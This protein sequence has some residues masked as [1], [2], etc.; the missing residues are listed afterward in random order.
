VQKISPPPGFDFRTAVKY[1]IE[2]QCRT[3][4]EVLTVVEMDISVVSENME[5][6]YTACDSF[7]LCHRI[8]SGSGANMP[9]VESVP[10]LLLWV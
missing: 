7:F 9:L 2:I 10:E 3:R 5:D 1:E 8:E 4:F 6:L